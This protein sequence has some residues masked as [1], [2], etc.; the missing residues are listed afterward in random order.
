MKTGVLSGFCIS[1]SALI[2][3]QKTREK[4]YIRSIYIV[5]AHFA[6]KNAVILWVS[7]GYGMGILWDDPDF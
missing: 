1:L 7:Y 5:K 2:I 3:F 4:V 6:Q